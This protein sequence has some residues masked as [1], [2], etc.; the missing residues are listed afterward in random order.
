MLFEVDDAV[1]PRGEDGQT[2]IGGEVP[3]GTYVD[4]RFR[5]YVANKAAWQGEKYAWNALVMSGPWKGAVMYFG[6][7]KL[8]QI[9]GVDTSTGKPNNFRQDYSV[10]YGMVEGGGALPIG[11]KSHCPHCG[12]PAAMHVLKQ[13]GDSWGSLLELR[14]AVSEHY[15]R[16]KPPDKIM[17]GVIISRAQQ[18]IWATHSGGSDNAIIQKIVV[19][20]LGWNFAGVSVLKNGILNTRG[21]LATDGSGPS[22]NLQSREYQCAAPKLIQ[23]VIKSSDLPFA[24]SEAYFDEKYGRGPQA[25]CNKCIPTIRYMLCPV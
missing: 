20:E 15:P 11:K 12:L 6:A 5:S 16:G 18:Q 10:R 23:A 7:S 17:L 19:N 22:S 25:S 21:E 13:N 9:Q 24:M 14:H 8:R 3:R 2:E 4:G 1:R